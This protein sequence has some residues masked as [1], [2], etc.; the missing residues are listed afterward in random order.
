MPGEPTVATTSKLF[1][2]VKVGDMQLAHRVVLAPLTRSRANDKHV[3]TDLAVTYY[4]QRAST[5][6]TLLIT[7]ATDVTPYSGIFSK[8]VPGVWS[9][10]QVAAWK[11]IAD[12]VHA[13]GSFLF[14][15]I[16]GLGRA[17]VPKML[18]AEGNYPYVSASDVPFSSS[19]NQIPRPLTIAEIKE[20]VAAFAQAARNAVHSAGCDGVE[21]HC[22]HGYLVDQFTQPSTNHRT[23]EYGGSIE[24]RCRFALEVIDAVSDA[25]GESKHLPGDGLD[26]PVPT[27][28]YLVKEA[29]RRHPNLAYLHIPEP[30]VA[31]DQDIL[32]K[33]GQTN[34][35]F[36]EMW[37]P[38]AFMA[39]G[40]FTRETAIER[41]NATGD[42]IAFGRRFLANPD[43]PLKLMKDL[44]LNPWDRKWYQTPAG[45]PEG[46]TDYPFA[47]I[48][49][50][51]HSHVYEVCTR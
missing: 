38:R 27:F 41:A 36:R 12:A 34:D 39:A 3:H 24:N 4:S 16:W 46:Y 37:A 14:M 26:D 47:R 45:R 15:Q 48:L 21:I 13:K 31:G 6:G 32:V 9:D 2:P 22:A 20:Y 5:P 25:V 1:Q 29:A 18:K 11:K 8:H 19:S 7:E 43:L 40:R 42:L 44:P 51:M 17:G 30:G 49:S 28:S 23:D 50:A 33:D 10:E 35:I